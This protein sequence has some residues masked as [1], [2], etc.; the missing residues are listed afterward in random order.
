MDQRQVRTSNASTFGINNYVN[1]LYVDSEIEKENNVP[2]M[3]YVPLNNEKN[4]NSNKN[5]TNKSI[6]SDYGSVNMT[7]S[8]GNMINLNPQLSNSSKKNKQVFK[9]FCL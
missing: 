9:F 7:P 3:Q 4:N 1:R 6:N 2:G 5:L 8:K